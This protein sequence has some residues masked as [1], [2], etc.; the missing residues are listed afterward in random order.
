[1]KNVGRQQ[2]LQPMGGF[3]M[4]IFYV[5][6]FRTVDVNSQE[7]FVLDVANMAVSPQTS[8][9]S[10]SRRTSKDEA[11]GA[12]TPHETNPQS[13]TLD[14]VALQNRLFVFTGKNLEEDGFYSRTHNRLLKTSQMMPVRAARATSPPPPTSVEDFP[15]LHAATQAS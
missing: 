2:K 15:P 4:L 14:P 12:P 11:S 9:N 5:V 6:F 3:A 10:K 13:P 7:K 8:P 1:M